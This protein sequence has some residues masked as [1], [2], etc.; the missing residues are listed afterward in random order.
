MDDQITIYRR[1]K[2]LERHLYK[3]YV[4]KWVKFYLEFKW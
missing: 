2:I 4:Q 3:L 1:Q